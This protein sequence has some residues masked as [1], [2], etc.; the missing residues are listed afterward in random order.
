[1]HCLKVIRNFSLWSSVPLGSLD[2][3]SG[4]VAQFNADNC[5]QKVNLGVNTYRDNNGNPVVLES[6]IKAM[7]I[8]REKNLDNEY[9]PIEGLQS[10]IDAAIK[11]GYGDKYYEKNSKNIAGCQVLSGT[12]A[13]RLGFELLNKFVPPETKVLVPIPTQTLHPTIAKMAGLQ[14]QEYR[15]FDPTT[16]QVDFQ[17]LF[18]DLYTA[19]NGSIVLFHACSHNPTGCDLELHQWEQLLDLTKKKDLLPFFDMTYQGFTSGDMDKDAYAIRLFT[20][21]GMPI[22]L[23]QSFDQ[24]MGLSGQRIGCLSLVCSNEKEREIVNSQL[25]LIARSLWSCPPVHGARIAETVLNNPKIYQLWLKEV[26]LMAQRIQNMRYSFTK[27]LKELG[28][29]HDWSYLSKQFG[30]YSL[31]GI[32]Q[33]Q[34]NELMEK[35]HIYLLENG[36]ISIAGLNDNNIK[37]VAMAFHEVTKNTQI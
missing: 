8:I 17:G 31:T 6:V 3:M 30:L 20:E 11:L 36:G 4:I 16:R 26:R 23:G 19:P 27:A 10:F 1:M 21:A 13:I 5:P 7:Q 24:N 9:P 29:P 35:Y 33:L 32:G 14:S 22:I 2:P 15:Y 25:N 28:S 12:G 34:I 37:Y 18:Q